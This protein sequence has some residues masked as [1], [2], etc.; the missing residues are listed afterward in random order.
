[1]N[2]IWLIAR[3]TY[4]PR[5]RSATFLIV[6][7]G[8]P[9]LMVIVAA[10]AVAGVGAELPRVGYVDRT[11]RLASITQ[12]S[13]NG[14]N[15]DLTP[16]SNTDS[17]RAALGQGDIGGYLVIPEG[18]F[19]GEVP[20][21]YGKSEPGPKLEEGLTLFMRRA[22]LPDQSPSKIKRLSDPA[23]L[24]YVAQDS[25]QEVSGGLPMVIRFA[26]PALLAFMFALA[27]FTG[28]N[29]MGAA[30]VREKDQRAMEMV[31]TSLAPWELVVGKVLGLALL[32][33]TQ[34]GIWTLG[35]VIGVGL[36]LVAASGARPLSVPWQAVGWGLLLGIPGYFTYATLAAGLGII[37]GDRQQARQLAG[38][39]GFI[40]MAPLY[41]VSVVVAAPDGPAAVALTMF[42]L[43]SPML[44]LLRMVLTEVPTWQLATSAAIVIVTLGVNVWF[45]AR[46]FR[47]AMLMYGQSLRPKQIWRALRGG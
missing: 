8:L 5:V 37:A 4:G 28:A 34:I 35:V 9:A 40:G 19:E 42:P 47:A 38:M 43:T 33:L 20:T 25:G 27:V 45:V 29:Q 24:V 10:I 23:E 14:D 39:L 12:V 15:L 18:Y 2:K 6:T 46:I 36:A 31:V 13:V 1:M 17:A 11:G 7:F 41:L 22:L 26:T 44:A 32:T 30:M 3:T 16:F 21:F